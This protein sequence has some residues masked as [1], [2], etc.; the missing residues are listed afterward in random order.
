MPGKNF[1]NKISF[2]SPFGK[3]GRSVIAIAKKELRQL[4]RDKRLMFVI[5]FFP[6]MLLI[7]F[8]YA[9]NFDVKHVKIAVYDQERSSVSREF[10]N[11]LLQSEYFDLVDMISSEEEINKYLDDKLAQ[12]VIVIPLDLSVR[13]YSDREV[14]IQYLIDGVDGNTANIITNYA[15][16]AT[17][18]FNQKFTNEIL[19]VKGI[20]KYEPLKLEPQFWFN[21]ELKTS[22]FLVPGLIAMILIVTAVISVALSLVKEK[23]RGT[24]EQIN[25]S[26]LSSLE[27]IL[28]KSLPFVL[29]A[30][31]NAGI[32]LIASYFLFGSEVKGSLLL[33][34]L[35]TL[36]FLIASTSLGIFI[37]V[38]SDSQQ[39]AFTLATFISLL[40][41]LILSGFIFPI[42]S[43]PEIIQI[44]T[45]VTPVKFFLKILRAIMLRGVGIETF[46]EQIIYL[47]IFTSILILLGTIINKRNTERA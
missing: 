40:P 7:M 39:V 32:I 37:S 43:M 12:C 21:P 23:E 20:G 8:G 17:L 33:L 1:T 31:L 46:W 47:L 5:F 13:L 10:I 28:G 24:I 4:K 2:S 44:I 35:T 9:V 34:F 19:A 42:E 14:K 45:N 25:V 27:L 26:P 3:M 22:K 36:I 38:V 29:L 18:N 30:L 15:N 41:S 11:S 16:L 6:V